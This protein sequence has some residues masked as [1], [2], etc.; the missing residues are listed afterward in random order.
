M[1][2]GIGT[3]LV[4][5]GNGILCAHI[6]HTSADAPAVSRVAPSQWVAREECLAVYCPLP[7]PPWGR[8]KP[9]VVRAPNAMPQ[10]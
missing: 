10:V 2:G 3:P 9:G 6:H 5:R 4:V 1:G 8:Q 7:H